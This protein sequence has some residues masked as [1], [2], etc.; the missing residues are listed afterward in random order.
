MPTVTTQDGAQIYYK[1]WGPGRRCMLSHGWPL[2]A[3]AGSAVLFLAAQRPPG[4]AHDRRGHGRST[5]TWDGNEMDTYADD[6]ATLIET[7]DLTDLTLVGH[8]TGGGE[9]ARYVGPARQRPGR[10]ARAG[11]RG[12]AAHAPD[13]R[14][15]GRAADRDVR[16]H[17]GGRGGRPLPALPGSGRRAVLRRQPAQRQR[18]PGDAGRVLAA[19]H[20]CGHRG[21]FE[22]IAA[23]SE[24]DF[25]PD[26]AKIDVPTLVIHGDD[27]QI[28]PFEV[29]GKRSAEMIDGAVLKVYEGGAHGLPDTRETASTPTSSSS[30]TRETKNQETVLSNA[31]ANLSGSGCPSSSAVRARRSVGAAPCLELIVAQRFLL[32]CMPGGS[33]CFGPPGASGKPGRASWP[34]VRTDG[35]WPRTASAADG[36]ARRQGPAKGGRAA[37]RRFPA[38]WKPREWQR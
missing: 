18:L 20:A 16:R 6:L 7:L 13:R 3:D 33:D 27:D 26:L 19:G 4:I 21:A 25:R 28:V 11:L 29:G 31:T 5:Q 22:C 23:F 24:T 35:A 34:S 8:S 17:P 1:D 9:I 36:G 15:P 12:P 2:N 14:Q 38:R 10:E 30:S 32:C 37:E